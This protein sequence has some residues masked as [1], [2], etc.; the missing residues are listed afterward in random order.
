MRNYSSDKNAAEAKRLLDGLEKN[1]MA[2][3]VSA[4]LNMEDKDFAKR[5]AE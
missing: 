1:R 4:S 2:W 3:L 5:G